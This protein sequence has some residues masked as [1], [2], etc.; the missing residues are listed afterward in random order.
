MIIKR[1]LTREILKP[2]IAVCSILIVIFV[3]YKSDRYLADVV[4]GLLPANTVAALLFLKAIIALE[5]LLPITLYLSVVIGLGRLYTDSEMTALFACGV[6]PKTVLRS[7]FVFSLLLAVLVGTLSLFVRPWAY[8]KSYRITAQAETNLDFSKIRSG[9]FYEKTHR[10][11]VIFVDD[12]DHSAISNNGVFTLTERDN[13]IQAIVAQRA[14]QETNDTT[15]QKTIVF[16]D[17]H[18][19]TLSRD[20]SHDYII[21]FGSMTIQLKDK[22]HRPEYKRKAAPTLQLA[23]STDSY[24]IAEYQW[25]LSTAVSTVLLGLLGIP[26][27]RAAPRQGK[28]AKLLTAVIIY[29]VYYILVAIARNWV[30]QGVIDPLPGIWWAHALLGCTV[31][32]WFTLSAR[33]TQ[34][35]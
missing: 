6:S 22:E 27:S 7:V 21:R 18:R 14:Y 20:G 3:S 5:V 4:E 13:A 29:T 2:L 12:R 30:E 16:V 8:E 34:L 25:R 10:D 19:Y 11:R 26:L 24:D 15:G 33:E 32:L 35:R 23:A 9:H 1:Y 31:I 17:G 28:Y